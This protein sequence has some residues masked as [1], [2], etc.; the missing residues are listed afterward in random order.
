MHDRGSQFASPARKVTM[1]SNRSCKISIVTGIHVIQ[2]KVKEVDL[3]C[4]PLILM[5]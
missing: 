4:L 5:V 1:A 2:F 3:Q